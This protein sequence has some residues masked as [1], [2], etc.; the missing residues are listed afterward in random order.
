MKVYRK[1]PMTEVRIRKLDG[2]RDEYEL[3][4]VKPVLLGT[5]TKLG[6]A[7]LQTE[8]G[9]QYSNLENVISH[10]LDTA[11]EYELSKQYVKPMN[12][13]KVQGLDLVTTGKW[14]ILCKLRELDPRDIEKMKEYFTLTPQEVY[15][16]KL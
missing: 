15:K 16:L 3:W 5:A 6:S 11:G 10:Y 2:A 8:D 13:K 14:P 7:R 4:L 1:L 9:K 12:T